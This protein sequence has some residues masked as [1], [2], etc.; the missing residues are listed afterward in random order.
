MNQQEEINKGCLVFTLITYFLKIEKFVL[1][2]IQREKILEIFNWFKEK[3]AQFG[4]RL[5]RILTYVSC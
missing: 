2:T 4:Q 5:V 1:I 3:L